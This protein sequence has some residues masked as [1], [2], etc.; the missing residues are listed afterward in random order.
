MRLSAETPIDLRAIVDAGL[1]HLQRE[2]TMCLGLQSSWDWSH[3]QHS[4]LRANAA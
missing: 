4:A 1:P 3:E 2:L